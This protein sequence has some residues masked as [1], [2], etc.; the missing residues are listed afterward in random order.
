MYKDIDLSG[1]CMTI[2]EEYLKKFYEF[3]IPSG[4]NKENIVKLELDKKEVLHI[5]YFL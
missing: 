5:K 3:L 1:G 4:V 2:R